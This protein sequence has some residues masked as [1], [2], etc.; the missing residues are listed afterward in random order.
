MDLGF[1][2]K[3]LFFKKIDIKSH[4]AFSDFRREETDLP[5]AK[6]V[7]LLKQRFT[8]LVA[9]RAKKPAASN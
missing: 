4:E 9:E 5:Y 7:E 6:G 1:T 3:I 2:G 8:E